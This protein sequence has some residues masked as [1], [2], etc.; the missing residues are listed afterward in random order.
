[1]K[2]KVARSD[3]GRTEDGQPVELYTLTNRQGLVA[4]V[5]TFGATLTELWVPD[6]AGVLADVVLGFDDLA[7]YRAGHPFFGSTVGRVAGRIANGRFTLD[8]KTYELA[9]ND[10]ANSL[11]GGQK[12]FDKVLWRAEIVVAQ[13]SASVRFSYLSEGGEE[14]Y[15]GKLSVR[16]DYTLTDDDE[17]RLDYF[18]ETD[19]PTPVNLTNHSYFNLAG[20]GDVLG[21]ELMLAA[22]SFLPVASDLVPT[23]E[24]RKVEG[25]PMDF[26]K[27]R[28]L[29]EALPGGNPG[30]YD[31]TFVLREGCREGMPAARVREPRSGRVM[32]LHTTEPGV[33]LYTGN[34]LDGSNVGK[35]GR[36]YGKHH[37]FCLETQHYPDSVNRPEFPSVILRPGQSFRSATRLEFS[38]EPAP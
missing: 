8:G 33:Q 12:G 23:G 21:H 18:A 27:P 11:H 29:G 38:C 14:G 16:V 36:V 35:G 5:S 10:G 6:R 20:S 3:W 1:M 24:I 15:P 22:D 9:K 28:R 17:L 32:E 4:K 19:R 37:G 2:A 34:F 30:G 13:E 7:G 31:H 26:R 25:T